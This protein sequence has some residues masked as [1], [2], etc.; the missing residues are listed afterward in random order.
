M[1]RFALTVGIPTYNRAGVLRVALDSVFAQMEEHYRGRVEVLIS[2]NASTDLTQALVRDYEVRYPDV[3]VYR[4]NS[5]NVGYSRNVDTV[6]RHARGDFVLLLSDD[7][8]LERDTLE[9]VFRI[10][11]QYEN[12]SAIFL[13]PTPY[14]CDLQAPLRPDST[15]PGGVMYASGLDVLQETLYPPALVSG[16]VIR[17]ESWLM[18]RPESYFDTLIVHVLTVLRMF[19][20]QPH[21]SVYISRVSSIRYR[22]EGTGCIASHD[23]LFPFVYFLDLLV[24]CKSIR[25]DCPHRIF[26]KLHHQPMRSIAYH[27]ML[28]KTSGKMKNA[29]LL[30]GRLQELSYRGDPLYWLNRV[31]LLAPSWS[32]RLPLRMSS[33]LLHTKRS[34]CSRRHAP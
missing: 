1:D 2:D 8:A 25:S 20:E 27:I 13:S 17:R 9:T 11:D 6:M 28:Q 31:L 14:D 12:L 5:C 26:V 4:R 21:F 7:D 22:T 18:A 23:P 19:V 29:S 33:L 24:G 32:L 16:Y 30:R 15:S 10:L 34:F 3:V